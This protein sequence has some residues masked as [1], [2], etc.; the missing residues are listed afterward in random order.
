MNFRMQ[1]RQEHIFIWAVADTQGASQL[2]FDGVRIKQ[3]A[4][5]DDY[6]AQ[7]PDGETGS[8]QI[9]DKRYFTTLQSHHCLVESRSVSHRRARNAFVDEAGSYSQ[10]RLRP[11]AASVGLL[12]L[13][14]MPGAMSRPSVLARCAFHGPPQHRHAASRVMPARLCGVRASAKF[15]GPV[16]RPPTAP[17]AEAFNLLPACPSVVASL[18]AA[19][20]QLVG[21]IHH[22][23]IG[24]ASLSTTS[25]SSMDSCSLMPSRSLFFTWSSIRCLPA[26]PPDAL[27]AACGPAPWRCCRCRT[28]AR[29][30]SGHWRPAPSACCP[31]WDRPA[32]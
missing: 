30:Q 18:A 19:R 15:T 26:P 20:A 12:L 25:S 7:A 27:A 14:S 13:I 28:P 23:G 4:F 31:R 29:A 16:H 10:P 17:R 21:G 32:R 24:A 2:C 5:P 9:R 22:R 1:D 6:V 3:R 11:G 8:R